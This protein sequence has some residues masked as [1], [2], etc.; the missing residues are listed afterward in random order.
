MN[1]SDER[2][3]YLEIEKLINDALAQEEMRKTDVILQLKNN[4][5]NEVEASTLMT[6]HRELFS[7]SKSLLSALNNIERFP[8]IRE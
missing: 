7:C 3:R 8:F 4:Q 6:V 2:K 5:L 1:L